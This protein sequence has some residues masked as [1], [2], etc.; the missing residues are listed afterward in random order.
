MAG[1]TKR[2]IEFDGQS[3]G[4]R[5]LAQVIRRKMMA[6]TY[7]SEKVYSRKLKHKNQDE[8]VGR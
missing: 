3:Y 4:E 5:E 7:K 2:K 8:S 6:R 1:S